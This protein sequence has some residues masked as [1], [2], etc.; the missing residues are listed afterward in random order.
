[1][2]RALSEV[3]SGRRVTLFA[4]LLSQARHVHARYG[5]SWLGIVADLSYIRGDATEGTRDSVGSSR[6]RKSYPFQE[7]MKAMG[8]PWRLRVRNTRT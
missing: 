6:A 3:F 1:M 4:R 7:R 2:D 8:S 5:T